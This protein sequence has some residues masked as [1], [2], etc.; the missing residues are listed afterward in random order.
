MKN[1]KR[2]GLIG[3]IFAC[4]AI[5]FLVGTLTPLARA[6]SDKIYKELDI[7]TRVIEVIDKQYVVAVDEHKLIDGAIRG[8]LAVLDPYTVFLPPQMYKDFKSDTTGKFGGVGIEVTIKDNVLTVMAP[9]EDSPAHRAGIRSGDRIL[10]I[11][12]RLTR[13]MTLIDAVHAMRGARGKKV[14][15]SIFREGFTQSKDIVIVREIIEVPSVKS[16]LIEGGYGYLRITSFQEKTTDK[17]K[18]ALKD[19]VEQNGSPLKGILLDL[20]DDPGGL[21]AEAA[22][23]C[24]VFMEKG[25][26][27]S[28]RGRD[29]KGDVREAS[30]NSPYEK[31]PL[32]V[33]INHGSASA[34]EIVAGALQD[35]GRAKILGSRSFGKGSVQTVLDMEDNA[36]LKI[37]IAR[38]Y[39]PKGRSIDG[40][41]VEPDISF[42][43]DRL[44]KEYAK[45]D[46]K[47]R[48][49]LDKYQKEKAL[50]MLKKF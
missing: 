30:K 3:L 11:D 9:L 1:K 40:E 44:K 37:T 7:F 36:A 39:T 35:V 49:P 26:I 43:M 32:L 25:V 8:M 12:S 33:L 27:V 24:D 20:R 28:T 14:T 21:L 10:K 31:I 47:D 50:E 17:L 29:Q 2:Y 16:E 48:P 13:D 46:E 4:L 6:L 5:G 19:L 38:Y 18:G 45:V 41:G 34:S 42:D 15:L 23:V 22:D